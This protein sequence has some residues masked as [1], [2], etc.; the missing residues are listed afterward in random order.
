[1]PSPVCLL[2]CS[3]YLSLR[4]GTFHL[5]HLVN[6]GALS[7]IFKHLT[8]ICHWAVT[9]LWSHK[10]THLYTFW[11]SQQHCLKKE[12]VLQ[13]KCNV[14]KLD[15]IGWYYKEQQ[16]NLVLAQT[17]IYVTCECV[18][19]DIFW[20]VGAFRSADNL[21]LCRPSTYFK[22]CMQKITLLLS[23]PQTGSRV[24]LHLH[25]CL[26]HIQYGCCSQSH[27]V[28]KFQCVPVLYVCVGG[29]FSYIA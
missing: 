3:S 1:M 6:D 4:C 12:K 17:C 7:C 18:K 28:F 15:T 22:H 10:L 27:Y 9:A 20:C 2:T 13:R 11:K 5:K 8:G 26:T 23:P 14:I 16:K 25:Q 21:I 24:L 29:L 19:V